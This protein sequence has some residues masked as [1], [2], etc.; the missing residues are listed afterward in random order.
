VAR[1]TRFV[2]PGYPQHVIVRGYNQ[3]PVFDTD[4]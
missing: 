1:L 3:E 2:P 4:R